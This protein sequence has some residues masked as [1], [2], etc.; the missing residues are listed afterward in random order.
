MAKEI[1]GN[2]EMNEKRHAERRS[3]KRNVAVRE[4]AKWTITKSGE[5]DIQVAP[6]ANVQQHTRARRVIITTEML[7][8]HAIAERRRHGIVDLESR[9]RIE[10]CR[11][12][13]KAKRKVRDVRCNARQEFNDTPQRRAALLNMRLWLRMHRER[14]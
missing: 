12:V 2:E 9:R 11:R 1:E 4:C 5:G 7:K 6:R 3:Q 8:R 10:E 14:A 13:A